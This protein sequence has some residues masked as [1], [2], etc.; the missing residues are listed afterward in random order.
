MSIP[1]LLWIANAPLRIT[2]TSFGPSGIEQ[3]ECEKCLQRSRSCYTFSAGT[4]TDL[5]MID[6]WT[7]RVINKD[8]VM[9]ARQG[10]AGDTG[11]TKEGRPQWV[12][13]PA[14]LRGRRNFLPPNG[15]PSIKKTRPRYRWLAG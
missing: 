3:S 7:R 12:V 8:A 5:S 10:G 9:S 4:S 1:S 15:A 13:L 2:V 14:Y 6:D 11:L